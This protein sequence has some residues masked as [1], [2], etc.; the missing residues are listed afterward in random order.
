[1]AL[2][3]LTE[4]VLPRYFSA[5][6]SDARRFHLRLDKLIDE[7]V[8]TLGGG[9]E[10]CRPDYRIDR[11]GF[12]YLIIEFVASGQGELVINGTKNDLVPG[13]VFVY[14]PGVHHCMESDVFYP[15]VKYFVVLTGKRAGAWLRM[16]HLRPGSVVQVTQPDRIRQIWDDLIDFGLGDRTDREACCTR[17]VQYL[18]MKLADLMV[19]ARHHARA[20]HTYQRCRQYIEEHALSLT[21]LKQVAEAC[22]IDPA[23]LCRLF[24]RFGRE[25]PLHYA[26][27][28]RMNHAMTQLQ[29]TDRLIKDI[30]HELGFSDPANFTRAFRN[31]FGVAPNPIRQRAQ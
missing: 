16:N 30:A 26:Q 31:W 10:H 13:T 29:T 3:K 7:P 4:N 14:G 1:M 22:H 6:V 5:Q 24:Q 27:H 21:S 25:R 20:L 8:S 17:T 2:H 18:I 28:I 12:P 19:P 23:Y 9:Q 15:L 11:D